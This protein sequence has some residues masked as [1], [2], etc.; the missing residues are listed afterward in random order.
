MTKRLHS[1]LILLALFFA[2]A[3]AQE[4]VYLVKGKKVVGKYKVADVDY[5]TFNL[6]DSVQDG[7][8][9][10][11]SA[12]GAGKN[13]ISYKVTTKDTEQ[14]YGHYFFQSP[15]LD[16]MLRTYYG[17]TVDEADEETLNY[18]IKLLVGNYGYMDQGTQTFT[19]SNGTDDGYGRDFFVPA[20]QD[21][22][23]AAVNVTETTSTGGTLGDEVSL[24]KLSTL[25]PGESKETIGLKFLALDDEG[26]ATYDIEPSSGIVTLYTLFG[27]KR[28]L[29]QA[30]SLYGADYVLYAQGDSWTA[31]DWASYGAQQSWEIDGE[32]DYVMKVV[33]FDV[34]GD[35]VSVSDEQHLALQTG[36]CPTVS[37]GDKS[38]GDG[39]VSVA[40]TIEP[41]TVSSAH[42]RLML[43]NDL[44]DALNVPGATLD[45]VAVAGDAQDITSSITSDGAYTFTASDLS[46][47]W[48]TL[49]ISAT[50]DA[51]T[52]V[53][54]ASFHSH[55]TG[56]TWEIV[57][58]TFP[59]A[60]DNE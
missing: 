46:R 55:L 34:N 12:V 47:G 60:T 19:I 45:Q 36:G 11:V 2:V 10:E 9:A 39:A 54:K 51:G 38:S 23:V 25:A 31:A 28:S 24:V 15:V 48:Y 37:V 8:S 35:R 7:L 16:T 18:V 14:Y 44:K 56:F 6:P 13:Y 33:G 43:E 49:L 5:L 57:S 30:E 20:G 40:F 4:T 53:T 32:N 50:T 41:Q 42:V 59:T 3:E 17:T 52:T 22:Y 58:T 29:D 1:L 26:N 21:F 27:S